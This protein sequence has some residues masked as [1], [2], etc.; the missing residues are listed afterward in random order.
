MKR[1]GFLQTACTLT[2][3]LLLAAVCSQDELSGG[4]G[5]PLPE[6][7]Y[8]LTFTVTQGEPVASPQ[9]RVSDYDDTDGSHKSKWAT[10]DRIKVV[11]SEGSNDMETICTLDEN[12]NITN[13]N[14]QLYWKTPQTSKINAWY[15]NITGQATV[16]DNTVNLADQRSGLAYVLKAEE[17][18]GVSYKSGSISL[19][20]KHQLAKVRVKLVNGTYQGDLTNATVKINSQYTSCTISNRT[21]TVSGTTTGDITMHKA[22]YDDGDTYYEANVVPGKALK[23]QAFT[24]TAGEKTT[25]ANLESGITQTAGNAY[26]YTVTVNAAG[27]TTYPAGN[28]IP[29]ITDDGEYIIEGNGAQTTNSIVISGSPTVTLK[30]VNIKSNLGIEI[31]SGNPTILIDGTNQLQSSN[32]STIALTSENANVTIKGS[33]TNPTLTVTSGKYQAGIGGN[34]TSCGNIHIEGITLTANGHEAAPG[35]GMGL[36]ALGGR[37]SGDI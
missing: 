19:Q 8:P 16:T 3:A 37:K 36:S 4:K 18:T 17:K 26:T 27:P 23:D 2:A 15:S 5:E 12:G 30:N 35:I 31:K 14:P 11:V 1:K 6:G 22:A 25:Q 32:G 7:K 28:A 10:G 29:K 9:T 20:F 33:G 24:I 34:D 21:V 13:Y